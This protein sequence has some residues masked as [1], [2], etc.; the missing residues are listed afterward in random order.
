MVVHVI[1]FDG[2]LPELGMGMIPVPSP[3]SVTHL[4]DRVAKCEF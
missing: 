1:D 3:L 2:S 4:P